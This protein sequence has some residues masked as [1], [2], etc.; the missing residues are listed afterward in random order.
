LLYLYEEVVGQDLPWSQEIGRPVATR[1]SPSVLTREETQAILTLMTGETG[2]LARLLYGTGMRRKET[3]TLRVKDIDFD[4]DAIVVPSSC[5]RR[6]R[7]QG[8]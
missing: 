2:L 7:S 3:L 8:Q 1:R 5:H 6:A 4:R